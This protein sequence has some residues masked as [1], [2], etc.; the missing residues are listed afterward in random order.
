[1]VPR[2]SGSPCF[3]KERQMLYK[4]GKLYE[5]KSH[6]VASV[7]KLLHLP[8]RLVY[9]SEQIKPSKKNPLPD[10]PAGINIPLKAS[11]R[12]P[13]GFVEWRYAE[14]VVHDAEGKIRY[15]PHTMFFSGDKLLTE[16]DIELIWFILFQC[17]YCKNNELKPEQRKRPRFEIEDAISKAEILTRRKRLIA[18]VN[19]ML[20][21]LNVGLKEERLR[22]VAKAYFIRDVDSLTRPQIELALEHRIQ[23]EEKNNKNGLQKFLDITG[24]EEEL[25]SK[26][27]IQTAVDS[28]I[29]KYNA[30]K[31]MWVWLGEKGG[32]GQEIC[33][34]TGGADPYEALH[35]WM[36]NSEEFVI[37]L[38][39][40][41]KGDTV[42]EK[43][44]AE[45]IEGTGRAV[46]P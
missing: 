24:A 9:T 16:F 43:Q 21:D 14:N 25:I 41:L 35:H 22:R 30:N 2:L 33:R 13:V 4:N 39:D 12:T 6:E 46:N 1:M 27:K 3:K 45:I 19:T 28:N 11:I 44:K 38:E 18:K 15:M 42:V 29:I 5:L 36:V 20:Y 37:A 10:K 26:G 8:I 40:H 7:H 17:P 23:I 31:N 32:T 34:I